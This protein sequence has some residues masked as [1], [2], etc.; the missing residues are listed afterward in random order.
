MLALCGA[1]E[2]AIG[3]L[4]ELLDES[5]PNVSRHTKALREAGLLALR[6]QGRWVFL[7]LT[8]G[9]SSDPVVGDALDAGRALCEEDGSLEAIPRVIAARDEAARAFF[10]QPSE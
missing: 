1:E 9:V 5:Q 4:A 10:A 7:R 6:K 2:L 8:G 3:E